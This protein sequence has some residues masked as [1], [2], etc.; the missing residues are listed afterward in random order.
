MVLPVAVF[1]VEFGEAT[2]ALLRWFLATCRL[3]PNSGKRWLKSPAMTLGCSGDGVTRFPRDSSM[4][5]AST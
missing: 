2:M 4:A 5:S 3:S 1:G